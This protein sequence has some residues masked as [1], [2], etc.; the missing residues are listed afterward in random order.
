[1]KWGAYVGD[2]EQNLANFETLV[3]K[4]VDFYAD[5]ESWDNDFPS[6]LSQRV[7]QQHKTLIIFWE[8]DFGYDDI[9][10]GSKD[11]YIRSFAAAAQTYGYPIILVPFDEMNLN[12]EAWGYGQNHNTP[13]KFQ[14]AWI[15]IHGLF[16]VATN[17]KFG[18]DF[19]NVSIPDVNGNHYIDYYPGSAY[20]DYLGADGFNFG[21]P[22]QNFTTIFDTILKKLAAYRKPIYIFSLACIAGPSKAAWISDGLGIKIYNYP[23]VAG[24]IWFNQGGY[25]NWLV[26]SDPN[27]LRA[28]RSIIP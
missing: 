4:P 12:E 3:G 14:Q 17:V 16:S 13:A 7:G 18:L 28:F 8:P 23:Y 25:P 1:L 2:G 9:N 11:N 19:N 10:N 24:W 6:Q 21:D 20:V 27:S 5:F 15:R 26:N 22:Q